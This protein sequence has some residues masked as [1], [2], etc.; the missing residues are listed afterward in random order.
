MINGSDKMRRC[1]MIRAKSRGVG[2]VGPAVRAAGVS[3]QQW[4]GQSRYY[5]DRFYVAGRATE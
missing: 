3:E 2:G 1:N 5:R 4:C